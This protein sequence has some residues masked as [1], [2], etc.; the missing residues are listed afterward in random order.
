[1]TVKQARKILRL[2]S[3]KATDDQIQE[4]IS[5]ATFLSEVFLD[6][7]SKMKPEDRLKL[8]KKK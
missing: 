8:S 1:M 4:A 3:K 2:G 7:W 6:M 5:S